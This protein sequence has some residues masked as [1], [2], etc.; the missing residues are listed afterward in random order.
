M[1]PM[2]ATAARCAPSG[3]RIAAAA[4]TAPSTATARVAAIRA[5][6]DAKST[7]PDIM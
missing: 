7:K 2:L 5:P 1:S 4:P 6:G 3:Y